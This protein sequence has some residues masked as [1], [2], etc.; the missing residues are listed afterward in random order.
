[1]QGLKKFFEKGYP[2]DPQRLMQGLKQG[3]PEATA[4][5]DCEVKPMALWVIRR[6][7]LGYQEE[8]LWQEIVTK[9]WDKIDTC[10]ADSVDLL[11]SWIRSI[12]YN[13]CRNTLRDTGDVEMVPLENA[14]QALEQP[15]PNHPITDLEGL[16]DFNRTL[17]RV[18]TNDLQKTVIKLRY[19]DQ[20]SSEEIARAL[21]KPKNTID[22]ALGRA[23]EKFRDHYKNLHAK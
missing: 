20:L 19:V 17:D 4:F 18:L 2:Q 21:G 1:M 12:A 16:D 9:V 7:G 11:V 15:A 6:F 5:L 3:S 22:S 13:H 23:K 8:D 14:S 10:R